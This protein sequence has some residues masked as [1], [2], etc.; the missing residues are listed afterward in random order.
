MMEKPARPPILAPEEAAAS[1]DSAR[2]SQAVPLRRSELGTSCA[3]SLNWCS[4]VAT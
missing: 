2:R 1:N 4:G 3:S